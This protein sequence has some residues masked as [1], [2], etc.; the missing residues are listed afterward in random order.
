MTTSA[1]RSR[2]RAPALALALTI[3]SP[4][5]VFARGEASGSIRRARFP[6]GLYRVST[7]A[8]ANLAEFCPPE[9]YSRLSVVRRYRNPGNCPDGDSP[10]LKPIVAMPGDVVVLSKSGSAG[11]R[12]IAAEH[13]AASL[14]QQRAA[15]SALSVWNISGQSRDHLGCIVLSPAELRQPVL[16]PDFDEH[17]PPPV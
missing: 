1:A 16:W 13:G 9:P 3:V 12:S 17:H 6:L 7:G 4:H 8:D 10:L 2:L 14:G 5:L 11:Q 15:S